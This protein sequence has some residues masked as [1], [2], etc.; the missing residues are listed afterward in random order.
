MTVMPLTGERVMF[1][2][3]LV[4][5]IGGALAALWAS[6]RVIRMGF[7]TFKRWDGMFETILRISK[8]F[9]INGGTSLRDRVQSLEDMMMLSQERQRAFMLDS[10]VSFFEADKHGNC[11]YVNNHFCQ[12]VGRPEEECVGMEWVSIIRF[13]EREMVVREWQAAVQQQRNFSMSFHIITPDGDQHRVWM[14]LSAMRC[15]EREALGW[16]G[17]MIVKEGGK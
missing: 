15:D 10:S 5:K 16:L 13:N 12:T 2:L 6:L 11:V 8:E 7:R 4:A 3:E 9:E 1:M 17:T 14:K